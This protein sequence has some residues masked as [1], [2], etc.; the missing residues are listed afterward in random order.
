MSRTAHRLPIRRRSRVG[1]AP[2]GNRA[3]HAPAL[4][5]DVRARIKSLLTENARAV[6]Q[7]TAVALADVRRWPLSRADASALR[8]C[9]ARALVERIDPWSGA[10][11]IVL[12]ERRGTASQRRAPRCAGAGASTPVT[13]AFSTRRLQESGGTGCLRRSSTRLDFNVRRSAKEP[14]GWEVVAEPPAPREK[15]TRAR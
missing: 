3:C 4:V 11:T 10:G 9:G 2:Q 8:W 1:F 6:R 5:V 12:D 7:T 15:G 13:E 14:A